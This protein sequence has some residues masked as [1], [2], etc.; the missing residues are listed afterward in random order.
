VPAVYLLFAAEVRRALAIRDLTDPSQGHH[1]IQ[2]L[3]DAAERA[4]ANRWGVAVQRRRANPVVTVADNYD[5]LGYAPDAAACDARYSRYLTDELMLRAHTSA[6]IPA[7]LAALEE[8]A[9]EPGADVA[10]SCPGIVYRR[11]VIDRQH[12]GEPHQLDLWRIRLQG[13]ALTEHDLDELIS[14]LV[15]AVL[16]GRVWRTT[17]AVHPYTLHG[18]QVDVAER[19]G[20]VEI[21]EC[22]LA[23]PDVL[24]GAG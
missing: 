17:P 10:L 21:G 15:S 6:G 16:P 20:W 22:G 4:L 2:L 1:A 18:R 12:V 3:I 7:A 19:D 14:T 13:P 8:L 11:D 9:T 5:R 23:H 24:V